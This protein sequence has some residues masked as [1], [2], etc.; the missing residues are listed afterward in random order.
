MKFIFY[1]T[2]LFVLYEDNIGL[3]TFFA[4]TFDI[5]NGYA[6]IRIIA[7]MTAYYINYCR[8][9]ITKHLVL[10]YSTVFHLQLHDPSIF[11]I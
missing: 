11:T 5:N 3:S 2:S 10:I 6:H 7:Q 8:L 1:R 9:K 4:C